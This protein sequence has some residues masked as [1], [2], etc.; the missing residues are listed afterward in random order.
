MKKVSTD[1]PQFICTKYDLLFVV[2]EERNNLFPQD[3]LL[4]DLFSEERTVKKLENF[5]WESVDPSRVEEE[6]DPFMSLMGD[7]Y[8]QFHPNYQKL[9]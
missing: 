4:E 5:V 7:K 6:F 2:V 3:G 8:N 9:Q 1:S